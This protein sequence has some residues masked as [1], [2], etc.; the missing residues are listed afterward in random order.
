LTVEKDIDIYKS[1]QNQIEIIEKRRTLQKVIKK[2]E[3]KQENEEEVNIR[4]YE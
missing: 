2:L 4:S 1:R 3:K